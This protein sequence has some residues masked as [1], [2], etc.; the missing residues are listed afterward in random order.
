MAALVRVWD[1]GTSNIVGLSDGRAPVLLAPMNE[2][3]RMSS[4]HVRLADGRILS[5]GQAAARLAS[6]LPGLRHLAA[7]TERSTV[8]MRVAERGYWLVARNRHRLGRLVPDRAAV[9][10]WIG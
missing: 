9:S 1:R 7:A 5:A 2:T 3:E 4:I 8:M 6:E 10:R